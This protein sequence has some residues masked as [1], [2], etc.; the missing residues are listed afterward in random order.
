MTNLSDYEMRV[1][2]NVAKGGDEDLICGA[3]MWAALES[4]LRADLV[5]KTAE[6]GGIAYDITPAGR[7]LVRARDAELTEAKDG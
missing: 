2:R 4:M 6:Q 7:A 3:A 5:R 1:L